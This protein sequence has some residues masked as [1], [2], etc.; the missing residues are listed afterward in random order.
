MVKTVK[1]FDGKIEAVRKKIVATTE[2]GAI[3]GEER[4]REHTD[5]LYG[6]LLSY[7]GKPGDYHLA[8][9]DTLRREL[10]DVSKDFEQLLS[11]DLPAFNQ[12]LKGKGK[13]EVAAPPAKIAVNDEPAGSGGDFATSRDPDQVA[14]PATL[15]ANFRLLH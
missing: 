7:E 10:D 5:E 4:I 15:P 8:Y 6:A 12:S 13:Q 11:K 2:G 3:T 1:D 9:I 14:G